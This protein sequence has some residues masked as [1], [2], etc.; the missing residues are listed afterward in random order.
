MDSAER[1]SLEHT[2][3]L[4]RERLAAVVEM[5]TEAIIVIDEGGRLRVFSP[6]AERLFGCSAHDAIGT[7]LE[8]LIPPRLRA[9]YRAGMQYW[10]QAN[11]QGRDVAERF[12]WWGLRTTGETFPC[13]VSLTS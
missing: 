8:R 6:A 10:R 3:L 1:N 5:A 2:M 13:E 12:I 11:P 7:L 9:P 4:H